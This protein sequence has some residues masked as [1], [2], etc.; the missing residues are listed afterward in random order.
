VTGQLV[1]VVIPTYNRAYCIARTIDSV[2]AQTHRDLEV[3]VVDDGST[4]GT[5]ELLARTY[6]AEPR[7]RVLSKPNGGVSAA[8]NHGIRAARGEFIAL[9]DSDDCFLPWKLEVQLA[10]L[11]AV[12]DAGMIWTDMDAIGP[13][14]EVSAR[15]FLRTM[16]GAYQW[17]EPEDL[18]ERSLPLSDV[19]ASL[20]ARLGN[21]RLH[22]G[23]IYSEM[24]L[25]NLVHTSTVLLRRERAE[26]V[27][28][29]EEAWRAGEDYPFHLRTC[30]EG[31]VAY[32]DV[33]SILYLRG[34]TDQL[35]HGSA[36]EL[37]IAQKFLA[38][39]LPV[40]DRDRDRIRL[41]RA[42]LDEVLADAYQWVGSLHAERGE[43]L[44]AFRTLS[45]SL[46]HK[47]GQPRV[48]GLLALNLLPEPVARGLR[49]L[50]RAARGRAPVAAWKEDRR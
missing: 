46:A 18:F 47:P 50:Y 35:T 6:P 26:K 10:C 2:L 19:D 21:P 4:D 38:T 42:V 44:D 36:N 3:V 12:P 40:L 41:P 43:H 13:D 20:A 27:G 22:A 24:V 9:L 48:A 11:A 30:R 23:D 17:L 16:Y 49:R 14:G 39:I 7:L 31:P 15:R 37:L 28:G 33:A 45:R 5:A 1:S 29:F 34:E 8:R 25:G 32:L